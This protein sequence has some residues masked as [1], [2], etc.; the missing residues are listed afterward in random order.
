MEYNPGDFMHSEIR[1][2]A[3]CCYTPEEYEEVIEALAAGKPPT[4]SNSG[5]I[6]PHDMVTGRIPLE[7][8]LE[9]GFMELIHNKDQHIKI[10]VSPTLAS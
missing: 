9:D 8:T 7:R 2:V 6:K 10:L 5:K 4:S 1:Y 3:S